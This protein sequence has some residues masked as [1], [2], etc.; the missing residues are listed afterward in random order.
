VIQTVIFFILTVLSV[1]ALAVILLLSAYCVI[2]RIRKKT[3]PKQLIRLKRTAIFFAVTMIL[4]AGLITLSQLTA[5]TPRIID[6]NGNTPENSIAEL[7]ELELNSRKQWISLR[8]WDKNAPVLL[9]LAG[10]PG[11]TQ[12]AAVRHELAE[13]EKHYVVVNWDQPGSGKSYYAEKTGNITA[14]TYI[15]DGHALTEYLKERFAQEKIYLVGESWG[16]A[17][18]VFLVDKYPESYHALIGTGQMVDFAETERMDYAK[19]LEI[20]QSKGDTATIERLIANGEPPYYGKDVTWKSAVYLN[21]LS[22][23]MVDNPK[24]HNSGYNTFRDI[25]SSEYGLLDKINFFR[26]IVN[27]FNHVYQQLYPIDMRADYT[28]LDVPVYFFLGRHD[29]NAPTV[30][31]EEYVQALDAPDKRIVWFEHSGHSPWINEPEKFVREVLSCFS[32]NKTQE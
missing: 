24:I 10:G 23:Y 31:V 18:G 8:G 32:E 11:G 7:R 28:K 14:Q 5:F 20:A 6:E 13:L 1:A 21:Y 30:L 12:M 27:T 22:A 15:Q 17:L 16:S 29:V 26:G 19:A 2:A 25:A 3:N 4:N 9:F